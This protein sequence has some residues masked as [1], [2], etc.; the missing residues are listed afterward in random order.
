MLF[1]A[2]VCLFFPYLNMKSECYLAILATFSLCTL[3]TLFE[4]ACGG[5]TAV[6]GTF[7]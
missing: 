2:K 4:F 1:N 7:L 3:S 5:I 6:V